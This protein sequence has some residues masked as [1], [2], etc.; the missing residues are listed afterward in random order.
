MKR[1]GGDVEGSREK[2]TQGEDGKG[3][4]TV[5]GKELEG[6]SQGSQSSCLTQHPPPLPERHL[7][8]GTLN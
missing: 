5:G 3:R 2:E 6:G 7:I 4:E 1:E 8:T